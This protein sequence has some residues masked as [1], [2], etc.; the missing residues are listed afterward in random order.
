[1]VCLNCVSEIFWV[2]FVIY[3]WFN[4]LFSGKQT[5]IQD[6]CH[7]QR[8]GKLY[9]QIPPLQNG[10]ENRIRQL[11]LFAKTSSQGY[12]LGGVL[13]PPFGQA[14]L[15][16]VCWQQ[17]LPWAGRWS[18]GLYVFIYPGIC[19]C[20]G[21]QESYFLFLACRENSG[22][23]ILAMLIATSL[24]ES[25]NS[26]SLSGPRDEK[27]R[28]KSV[29]ACVNKGTAASQTYGHTCAHELCA[30]RG[31]VC[32][33][34]TQL[35]FPTINHVEYLGQAAN[36]FHEITLCCYSEPTGSA[37]TRSCVIWLQDQDGLELWFWALN[38]AKGRNLLPITCAR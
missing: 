21:K 5:W 23:T 7:Q 14:A 36:V 6:F 25:W 32:C 33:D 29:C 8:C 31:Q 11:V 20:Q 28:G 27:G 22:L 18:W 19:R 10:N 4:S 1:M 35:G 38:P 16:N 12:Y 26:A 30:H 2:S 24:L 37:G 34:Y 13:F 15:V 17:R 9:R 3:T